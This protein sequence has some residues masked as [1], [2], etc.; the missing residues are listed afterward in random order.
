MW[1]TFAQGD[2]RSEPGMTRGKVGHNEEDIPGQA[3]EEEVG[4][5]E[6]MPGRSR[7]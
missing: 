4:R 3:R 7:A 1:W 2:A 5:V 6:E